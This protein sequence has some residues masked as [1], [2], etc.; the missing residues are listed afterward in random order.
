MNSLYR[1]IKNMFVEKIVIDVQP[2][3]FDL[4]MSRIVKGDWIDLKAKEDYTYSKGD[5]FKIALGVRMKLPSGYEAHVL[6]RSSTY[7]NWGIIAQ[8]SMGIIDNTYCGPNDEWGFLVIAMKDGKIN[9]GDR[10]C[11]FRI[12]E[13]Q[14]K[15]KFN[16]VGLLKGINRGGFGSTGIK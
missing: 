13:R 5:E 3:S 8:N 1:K 15:I 9:K 16:F 14:P 2:D 7:K 6:P 10:V 12:I 4:H 11:Q